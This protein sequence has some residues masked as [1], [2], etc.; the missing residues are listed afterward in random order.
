MI[1]LT[2]EKSLY[3]VP[4]AAEKQDKNLP[5]SVKTS[6]YEECTKDCSANNFLELAIW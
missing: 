4:V 5:G 2:P 6:T 1:P 3:A